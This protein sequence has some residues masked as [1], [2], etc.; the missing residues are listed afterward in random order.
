[1]NT[2]NSQI[3]AANFAQASDSAIIEAAKARLSKKDPRDLT[4]NLRRLIKA[5]RPDVMAAG[6]FLWAE[7]IR[8]PQAIAAVACLLFFSGC[9]DD[10]RSVVFFR[11]FHLVHRS[12]I[13]I[14]PI[15]PFHPG[16][17]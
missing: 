16:R 9:H 2:K 1:V 3:H 5:R 14:L 15:F 17:R 6:K 12:P 4:P 13:R 11:G 10:R 8:R 7:L